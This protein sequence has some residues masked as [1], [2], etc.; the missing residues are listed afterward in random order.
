MTRFLA[1]ALTAS[2]ALAPL[3][4]SSDDGGDG[5]GSGGG[6]GGL[7]DCVPT[8]AECYGPEGAS[9]P[10]AACLAKADN[11]GATKLQFRM[12]QLELSAPAVLSSP[13]MQDAI[14]TKKTTLAEPTCFQ[15]GDAQFNTLFELDT[16]TKT[17]TVGGGVPQALIGPAAG[18]TCYAEFTDPDSKIE[19]GP[20]STSYTEDGGKFTAIFDAGSKATPPKP[21]LVLPIYL[22]DKL[23]QYV[24]LPLHEVSLEATLSESNN[25]IGAFDGKTLSPSLSCVP[26]QG[27]FAWTNGGQYSAYVTVAESDTVMITSLGYSLCVLLSG[28]VKNWKGTDGTCKTSDGYAAKGGLPTGDWCAA[29]NSAGGCQDAYHLETKFAASAIKIDGKYDSSAKKCGG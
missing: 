25:C 20:T 5:G 13:F 9:G 6:G 29:T 23:D 24:L 4:C 11:T 26:P 17:L 8:A 22:E 18:G 12:S 19:I 16:A 2:M 1:F 3:G 27:E 10:G 7:T 15:N 14:I 28:D 21:D